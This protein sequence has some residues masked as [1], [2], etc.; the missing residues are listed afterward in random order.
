MVLPVSFTQ[1]EG[2]PCIF[3]GAVIRFARNLAVKKDAYAAT[4]GSEID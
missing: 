1:M 3:H 4:W 2:K